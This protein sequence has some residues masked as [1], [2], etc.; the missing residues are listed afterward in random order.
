MHGHKQTHRSPV[1]SAR[2]FQETQPRAQTLPESQSMAG[3]AEAGLAR[4]VVHSQEEPLA[5]GSWDLW[6][7]ETN[8]PSSPSEQ[9]A[10]SSG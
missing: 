7:L 6:S 1:H 10:I 2:D 3:N 4:T 9:P 8:G 5:G